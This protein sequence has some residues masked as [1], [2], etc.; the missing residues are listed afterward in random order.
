M[1]KDAVALRRPLDHR[2][3]IVQRRTAVQDV[4]DVVELN[5][6]V[7]GVAEVGDLLA[8][9]TCGED[10]RGLPGLRQLPGFHEVDDVHGQNEFADCPLRDVLCVVCDGVS[11]FLTLMRSTCCVRPRG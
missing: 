9:R 10:R 6:V 5:D 11:S 8:G 2:A 4:G 1:Q 3:D 7:V